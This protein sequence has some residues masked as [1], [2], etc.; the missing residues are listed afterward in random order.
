MDPSLTYQG[1]LDFHIQSQSVQIWV[2]TKS[3]AKTSLDLFCNFR[4]SALLPSR[5]FPRR[6]PENYSSQK[7]VRRKSSSRREL[8]DA[9]ADL[10][11]TPRATMT[12]LAQWLWGLA[13]LGSAWAVLTMGALGLELPFPCQEVLWPLPAYLLVSAGCYALGTVGYR[14]ATF[15]DCEDAARELQ[16]QILEAR[17]DLA[18]RGLR[19]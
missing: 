9:D 16:S 5:K 4:K 17:A 10:N 13:L 2:P 14:V 18:R 8:P 15:H 19:F 1:S 7:A 11:A 12:K 6:C 3:S